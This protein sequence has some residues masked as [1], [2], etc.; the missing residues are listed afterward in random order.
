MSI[1]PN[2]IL[3]AP[4]TVDACR[5]DRGDK[6]EQADRAARAR[7]QQGQA[8]TDGNVAGG[9]WRGTRA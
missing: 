7:E 6:A 9:Q 4:A 8:L 2:R 3:G 1:L 5:S